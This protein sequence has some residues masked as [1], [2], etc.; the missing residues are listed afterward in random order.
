LT[1]LAQAWAQ[2]T[3]WEI[4]PPRFNVPR[5]E[6]PEQ[7][8][9][10]RREQIAHVRRRLA[11]VPNNGDA[12]A[13]V[14]LILAEDFIA[15][16]DRAAEGWRVV[17]QIAAAPHLTP[18]VAAA[19]VK[20]AQH[21]EQQQRWPEALALYRRLTAARDPERAKE[22]ERR[23]AEITQPHVFVDAPATVATSEPLRLDLRVRNVDAVQ[24]EVRRVELGA[25]LQARQ[26]RFAEALLPTAGSVHLAR[27]LETRARQAHDWWR[28]DDLPEAFEFRAPAGAYV[29]IASD[30]GRPGGSTPAK[31][32]IIVSDLAAAMVVG[33]QQALLWAAPRPGSA[34]AG[35]AAPDP[36]RLD[37][38]TARFWMYGS[39]VATETQ[40]ED[41]V[42][43]FA[44]PGEARVLRDHRWVC[45][46][47][48]GAHLALCRGDLGP[49]K[50]AGATAA[51]ALLGG[52]ADPQVGQ[53]LTLA[54]LVLGG[55]DGAPAA[56]PRPAWRL[57]VRDTL[58]QIRCTCPLALSPAGAFSARVPITKELEGAHLHVVVRRGE[59]VVEN[60]RG[61]LS[62]TVPP[63]DAHKLV[64]D[65]HMPFR[66]DPDTSEVTV[67]VQAWYPWGT[68]LSAAWVQ[69]VG[70]LVRLPLPEPG[71]DLLSAGPL[72]Y[73]GRTD[74]SGH[75]DISIRLADFG[76]PAGPRALGTWTTVFGWE[77]QQGVS[78]GVTLLDAAPV[79]GWL[80]HRPDDP[81][82]GQPV[83][84]EVGWFDPAEQTGIERPHVEVRGAEQ[85]AVRLNVRPDVN[86]IKCE[87][88]RPQ[89][90]GTYEAVASIPRLSGAP[91][92]V[93]RSFQVRPRASDERAAASPV[94]C[95][96]EWTEHSGRAAARVS[97]SGRV[98][99]PVLVLLEASDPLTARPLSG[100][101]GLSEVLLPTDVAARDARVRLLTIG[102]AGI[103][104]LADEAV[105]A[106]PTQALVLQII[107][108]PTPA[109][110]GET[111]R[112]RIACT[113][114]NQPDPDATLL[115]RL[116]PAS[117]MGYIRWLPGEARTISRSAAG[118]PVLVSSLGDAGAPPT[119]RA[120]NGSTSAP[121]ASEREAPASAPVAAERLPLPASLVEALYEG[122]TLWIDVR[123][124]RSGETELQVPLPEMPGLYR[125][126]VLALTP[127]GGLATDG[128]IL[129]TRRGLRV[130]AD[131]P[132]RLT[133]GDRTVVAVR[134]ESDRP[135]P[136]EARLRLDPGTGFQIES[137]HV[138]GQVL[139]AD[140]GE[141][142]GGIPL[143]VPAGGRVWVQLRVEAVQIGEATLRAE[144]ELA[145]GR[146]HASAAYEVLPVDRP[147]AA[148]PTLHV[149]RTLLVLIEERE[150]V[151]PVT[152]EPSETGIWRSRWQHGVLGPD[153]RVLP[154]QHLLLREEFT[155]AEPVRGG[156]WS[157]RVPPNCYAMQG[158][159]QAKATIG[160]GQGRWLSSLRYKVHPLAAGYHA[161]EYHLVAVRPGVGLLPLPEVSVDGRR[162]GVVA[163]P[164]ELLVNVAGP[165]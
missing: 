58:D 108:P 143:M 147:A 123:S 138:G 163:E 70:R 102:G 30:A 37:A 152:G 23:I 135:E 92:R 161:Q 124:G 81:Q 153:D 6:G 16:G 26:G 60:V 39:F 114:A 119:V 55:R 12:L 40:F 46:V 34:T 52:P 56:A 20:L 7:A 86:G 50:A 106:D 80:L 104:V 48:A 45:L 140:A 144:V 97:I 43:R 127:G 157:L 103:E 134:L 32:L 69:T 90:S 149:K 136:T 141:A 85:P 25:W 21:C 128:L 145:G 35:A 88:W 137:I 91:L 98:P 89:V 154:G 110:P 73:K 18:A 59:H 4:T 95:A 160:D 13:R 84:F 82:P 148:A 142:S 132:A 64:I 78:Q 79:Y 109:L 150:Q 130:V 57:E 94:S 125:L 118:A 100:V 24:L 162:L 63:A 54:G 2:H 65:A 113:R 139:A 11:P 131:A 14:D 71:G 159:S 19:A 121:P 27:R 126:G 38:L 99:Q 158:A 66:H 68:P 115:A 44:L 151:D 146:Q 156:T 165:P 101:D 5:P 15:A 31:R 77:E 133:L 53:N 29:L 164:A 17:E 72:S 83:Q 87:P 105:R 116:V 28:S 93:S 120:G 22:A 67:G 129:D 74:A 3:E 10:V 96:A 62:L 117:D 112:I 51:V 155:L 8:R 9:Q 49:E 1:A 47:E 61:R 36:P 33:P 42:A 75:V 41:G 122:E 111:A 107:P 76:L